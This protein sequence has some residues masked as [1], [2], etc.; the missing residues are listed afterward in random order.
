[1]KSSQ[2][3]TRRRGRRPA[4]S[5]R[6]RSFTLAEVAAAVGG[7]VVGDP[8]QVVAG[9]ES[10]DRATPADLS[11]VADSGRAR[12][13]SASRAAALLVASPA[14]ACGR[15]CVVVANPTLAMAILLA[16]VRPERRPS[17]G[18]SRRAHVHRSARMGSGVCVQAGA[19]IEA[20][21][22]IGAGTIIGAGAFVGEGAEIGRDCRLYPLAAVM[23]RCRVG[24][25]C[26]LHPGAVIGADGFGYIWDGERHRKIPQVGIARLEDDVEVGANAAIDRATFGETVIGRGTKIDNLVQVGHNVQVGELSLLCGQAGIAGS[27]KLGRR[28]TLAGQV[29]VSD[30]VEIGDGAIVTGQGGI[31]RGGRIPAGAVVSGMPAAPHRDFLRR[32]AWIARLPELAHRVEQ[33][34]RRAEGRQED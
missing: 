28:V 13:V 25:R 4:R 12:D 20:G 18:I 26:V 33:L 14:D 11:W 22:T 32:A 3:T 17:P 7:S 19:T 6:E 15:P 5:R 30:H 31:V 29:G 24:A 34:E 1:M 9:V 21:A 2:A 10:L 23:E 8:G 27:S 16:I